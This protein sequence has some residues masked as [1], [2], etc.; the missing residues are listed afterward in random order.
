M[1]EIPK[2]SVITVKASSP[3]KTILKDMNEQ[4]KNLD[5]S[6]P[7]PVDYSTIRSKIVLISPTEEQYELLKKRLEERIA[8]SRGECIYEIGIGEG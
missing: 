1:E 6:V 8:D 2:V 4:F 5:M 3:T 7:A